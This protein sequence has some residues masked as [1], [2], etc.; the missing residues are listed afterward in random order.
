M[1]IIN[2]M[3]RGSNTAP[4]KFYHKNW[5][6]NDAHQRTDSAV[7][8]SRIA[9]SYI[10]MDKSVID[11][12]C[13]IGCFSF[14]MGTIAKQVIG[15]DYDTKAIEFANKMKEENNVENV[16]FI[17]ANI[18]LDK[19]KEIGPVDCILGLAVHSWVMHENGIEE[20]EKIIDWCSKNAS[21]NFIELQYEGEAG[22]YP[23]LKNDK[24]CEKY[25]KKYFKYVYKICKI[26][27]WG[28]RTI[29][30]CFNDIGEYRL[31]VVTPKT[32]CYLSSNGVFKKERIDDNHSFDNEAKY[33]KQVEDE[34]YFPV[35]ISH[36]KDEIL[37]GAIYGHNVKTL[38]TRQG[39]S[40]NNSE[41]KEAMYYIYNTLNKHNITHQ[42]INLENI[43][44]TSNGSL[45]LVDFE[46]A[47]DIGG[48]LKNKL[49][50]IKE[51]ASNLEMIKV[52]L[53][54]LKQLQEFYSK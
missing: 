7:R 4:D 10:F 54:E 1:T 35:Y 13:N 19:L 46:Y 27:G 21:V 14:G 43:I 36:N 32:K 3:Y 25:L 53:E 31:L 38:I 28:P 52:T 37:M 51:G 6:G 23:G 42:D 2:G 50:N 29:W 48:E 33:L 45:Y 39:I 11:L 16:D 17:N 8:L 5:Y 40:L 12:G 15:I 44:I 20:V 22:A 47:S 41:V 30:K 9:D 34:Q 49:I 26:N 24:D 18:T